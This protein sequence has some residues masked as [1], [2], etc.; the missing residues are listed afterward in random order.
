[1]LF[2]D[3]AQDLVVCH[4]LDRLR[5]GSIELAA[6]PIV[7]GVSVDAEFDGVV[8]YGCLGCN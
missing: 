6:H 3:E 1:L 7:F 2:D 8:G 4:F 5:R